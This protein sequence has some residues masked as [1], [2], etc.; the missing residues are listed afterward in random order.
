M[1]N[2]FDGLYAFSFGL[3]GFRVLAKIS[4]RQFPSAFAPYIINRTG[5]FR[6]WV[7][8]LER[9]LE[10]SRMVDIAV[11]DMIRRGVAPPGI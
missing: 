5:V 2:K 4:K 10:F 9:T 11:A 7:V 8:E 3:N 1:Q 6:G